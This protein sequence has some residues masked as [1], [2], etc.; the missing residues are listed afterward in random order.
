MRVIELETIDNVRDLG[1][2][3]VRA[4]RVVRRGLLY[5]G[6]APVGLSAADAALLYEALG[7]TCSIDLRCGW[8]RRAKP[9]A[10]PAHVDDLFIPFY[11]IDIVGI[12]YTESPDGDGVVGRDVAC[13]PARFYASLANPLTVGQMRQCVEAICER[14]C[15]GHPVYY[16]CSG[17]KDRAGIMTV[18][19]LSILGA[20]E[21]EILSDY[22][23]T[24]VAR[25]KH[26]DEN[27]ARFLKLC[28]GDEAKAHEITVGHSALPENL[29][30]FYEAIAA[31]YGSMDAFIERQLGF[32]DARRDEFRQATT[33]DQ[34]AHRK[35][36]HAGQPAVVQR[37][38][39]SAAMSSMNSSER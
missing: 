21:G 19:L 7:I 38:K 37:W 10:L 35:P 32:D 33:T 39:H 25:D 20:D 4:G 28:G 26:Y 36:I 13:T 16:H 29:E 6:S 30:V 11:D 14:A 17:G 15:A 12:E 5:R 23:F 27:F 34:P 8:E 1:G 3:P 31:S 22:L 24:N 9:S 2:I 18:L